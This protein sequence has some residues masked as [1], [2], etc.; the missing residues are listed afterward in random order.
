MPLESLH[1]LKSPLP[2]KSKAKAV[3]CFFT[4]NFKIKNYSM[5]LYNDLPQNKL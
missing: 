4:N 3:K 5:L 1:V 2:L